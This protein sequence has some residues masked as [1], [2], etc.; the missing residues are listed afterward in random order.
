[1]RLRPYPELYAMRDLAYRFHWWTRDS[2]LKGED[3]GPVQLDIVMERRKALEWILD[4]QID[5]DDMP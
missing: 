3:S 2:H 1:M 4:E 5:W